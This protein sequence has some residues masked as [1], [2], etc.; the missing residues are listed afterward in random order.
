MTSYKRA[1]LPPVQNYPGA[2]RLDVD[3]AKVIDDNQQNLA[4]ILNRGITFD[5]N[6]D[7]V[8]VTVT[9]HATPGTEFSVTHSLG[10][11]PTGRIIY[12]Q[13]KAG[14]L[15]AGATSDTATTMYF[16]SDA[17]SCAFKIIIF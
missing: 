9:S 11:I 10:K 3:M 15:Y 12:A 16:K 1:I 13:S 4:A 2:N 14:S 7:C 17:S 5:D 6:L 8:L